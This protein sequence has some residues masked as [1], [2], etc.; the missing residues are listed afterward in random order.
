LSAAKAGQDS[1]L[2]DLA[3]LILSLDKKDPWAAVIGQ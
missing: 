3:A 1:Q 2:Q